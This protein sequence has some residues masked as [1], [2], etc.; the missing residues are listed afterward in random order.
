MPREWHDRHAVNKI[1]DESKRQFYRSI[2]AEKKPYF[3]RYIYPE[4]SKEYNT[5]IKN[6]NRNALRQFGLTVD[7]L[8]TMPYK[9]LSDEQREFL[10]YYERKMP[11]GTHDCVMNRICKRF[12]EEF[13]NYISKNCTGVHFDYSFM[14][15]DEEYTPKQ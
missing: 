10:F 6:T 1:E 3:M 4:L 2:I 12:E 5:Y 11:I 9:S 7:E 8:Y 15:S 13:D 14:K